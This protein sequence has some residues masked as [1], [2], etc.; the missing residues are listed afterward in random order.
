MRRIVSI[1]SILILI[2][3][4]LAAEY[5]IQSSKPLELQAGYDSV[6][7]IGVEPIA[8][9]SQAYL[10]G[11]PFNIE[12]SYVAYGATENGRQIAT[13]SMLSNTNVKLRIT[14][15][16]MHHVSEASL[17]LPYKLLFTYEIGYIDENG[18]PQTSGEQE[19]SIT[20]SGLPSSDEK[21]D[22]NTFEVFPLENIGSFV[23][24]TSSE[25][26]K[27]YY[28]GNLNG[29]VY[30]QFTSWSTEIINANKGINNQNLPSGNYQAMVTIEMVEV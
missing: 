25:N 18:K 17:Y 26:E 14:A 27:Y 10:Q 2:S 24:Q 1:L 3:A 5:K 9:Q 19:F 6:A 12:E 22:S 11:M 7:Y 28:V 23:N 16:L 13:W 4:S 29:S 30:F 15:E 8:A 21:P 20:T